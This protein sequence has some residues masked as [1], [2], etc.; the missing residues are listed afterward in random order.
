MFFGIVLM[1]A[2][3]LALGSLAFTSVL[4]TS[5]IGWIF[6]I[7]GIVKFFSIFFA[8]Q[9][10]LASAMLGILYFI[11]GL[12]IILNPTV[13]LATLTLI[14]AIAWT[15][16]GA[17]SAI[18]ALFASGEDYRGWRIFGGIITF[19]LGVLVWSGWPE[20][21]LYIVGLFVG[22]DLIIA[23]AGMTALSY[24]LKEIHA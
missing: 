24:R 17:V 20:S 19:L 1:L 12:I 11:I 5:L 13:T 7:A 3:I 15:V 22:I 16:G 21:S 4:T 9:D 10:R 23:G 6:L 8:S 18:T 2:G 14:L